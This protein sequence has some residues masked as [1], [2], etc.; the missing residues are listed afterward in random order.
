M[1]ITELPPRLASVLRAQHPEFNSLYLQELPLL[2]QPV[3]FS[4]LHAHLL[5]HHGWHT[6]PEGISDDPADLSLLVESHDE[7]HGDVFTE[8]THA[9]VSA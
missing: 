7:D 1:K 9:E 5:S 2:P 6:N 8:H 4:D 3:G